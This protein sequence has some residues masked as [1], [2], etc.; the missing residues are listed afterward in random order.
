MN[1]PE[2]PLDAVLTSVRIGTTTRK[3]I[4][5]PGREKVANISLAA[6]IN[7]AA[8]ISFAEKYLNTKPEWT[9]V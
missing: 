6:N 1:P 2:H 4:I 7:L 9:N 5:V 8:D 3:I